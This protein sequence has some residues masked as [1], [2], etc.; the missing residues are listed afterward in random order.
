[1]NKICVLGS[2]NMDMV[3]GVD[4]LPK[5][6]ETVLARSLDYYPGGKGANQA[7]A[8]RRIGAEVT[9]LGAVGSDEEG[10]QLLTSLEEE[11]IGIDKIQKLG[12]KT[13]QALINVDQAGEN[14]IVVLAGAN[15]QVDQAYLEESKRTI[16]Y[17][18]L[19]L[20]QLEIPL[21]TVEEAFKIAKA[22]QV[23]TVL[24][25]APAREI[26]DQLLAKTDI[27]IPNEGETEI[28]TGIYP[29]TEEDMIK[30]A[31]I[32]LYKG[33]GNVI[34]TLG[35]KGAFFMNGDDYRMVEA[36]K[37]EAVDTT[38]AG[39]SFVGAFAARL[40]SLSFFDIYYAIKIGNKAAS[41]TVGEKGAQSSL[42]YLKDIKYC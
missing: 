11:G 22:D 6:G 24:N 4:S 14:N 15:G 33:V 2:I 12:A 23:V 26:S 18:D 19:L 38:A 37:V 35:S 1:M 3:M 34:I 21:A 42:P 39:D 13:G 30:A 10:D 29:H 40:N 31:K 27:I 8:A 41:I 16:R 7:V 28:L 20:A 9:M 5:P 32:L 25:P 17:S 36:Y